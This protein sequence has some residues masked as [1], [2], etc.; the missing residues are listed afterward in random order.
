MKNSKEL[1]SL[2]MIIGYTLLSLK[3]IFGLI[4]SSIQWTDF[5][6][7][8]I[9]NKLEFSKTKILNEQHYQNY[10][11]DISGIKTKH[12]DIKKISEKLESHPYVHAVRV[13]YHYPRRIKIE[14]IEREPIALL[15]I[16]PMVMLDEN[17]IVLPNLDNVDKFNL[18]ILS[19]F[20]PSV[21][22]YPY[23]EIVLSVKVKECIDWLSNLKIQYNSLYNNLS[24]MKMT[25]NNELELILNEEPTHVYLGNKPYWK[26]M[27]ILQK[28]E[29]KLIP[30]KITDFDY[31]DMRYNNQVIAKERNT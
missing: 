30:K 22:L 18:P 13:S 15:Q 19:D 2:I 10:L 4:F 25:S 28:F 21:E 16:D 5:K 12:L 29:E 8:L 27:N 20:N 11:G 26:R 23:G 3:I 7:I 31:L 1:K 14:L 24:E 17:G 9:V 6:N